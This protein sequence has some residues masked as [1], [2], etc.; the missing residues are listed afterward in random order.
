MMSIPIRTTAAS[1]A[2]L[3]ASLVQA[4]A[5]PP[6]GSSSSSSWRPL[7]DG[8]SLDGWDH[9]GPGKFVVEDGLLRTQDGMGLL[10]YTREKFGDC[11]IRVIYK[12]GTPRL[13]L[14]H[15][16]PDRRPAQGPMVCGPPRLRG[17]DHGLRS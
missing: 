16:H 4:H 14:R 2:L 5:G 9:V 7:F 15:I 1:L 6:Q 12:T 11:V 8:H 3:F 10:W 17:A 13:Q